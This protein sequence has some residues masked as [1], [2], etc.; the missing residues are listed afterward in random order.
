MVVENLVEIPEDMR[1]LI[2]GSVSRIKDISNHLVKNYHPD[3][4][5]GNAQKTSEIK[6]VHLLSS[7]VESLVS[8]K[9]MQLRSQIGIE[10]ESKINAESYGLFCELNA[11]DLKRVLSNL[12][13][14]ASEALGDTGLISVT[15]YPEK[16]FSSIV[17]K[18]NGRGIPEDI[19][20]TLMTRGKTY[21]KP[22]GSGLGLFH[23]KSIIEGL[24][25]H[26]SIE[27]TNGIGTTIKLLLPLCDSPD[28]FVPHLRID[29]DSVICVLDDD[30]SIHQIWKE[31]FERTRKTFFDIKMQHFSNTDEA[32]TW[33]KKN[34]NAKIIYLIDY[35]LLGPNI[36]GLEFIEQ[37]N[38]AS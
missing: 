21:G 31:R 36:N 23:A 29:S 2:R 7:L 19:L 35:E 14:N 20:P 28:W 22:N 25:G 38:L 12:I 34:N 3:K 4:T 13:N 32:T 5:H 30:A 16:S 9:R 26:I 33:I 6:E 1:L 10:V 11:Q 37:L 27:S 24:G 15:I 18:D 17:I 8:E